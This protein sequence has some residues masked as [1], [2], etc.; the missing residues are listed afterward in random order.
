M[1]AAYST[2]HLNL[3]FSS[4]E[5]GDR[6]EV[7]RKS[8]WPLLDLARNMGLP[9]GIE[10]SGST[11]RAISQLD[12]TWVTA[13]RGLVEDGLVEIIASG[14]SQVI[15][16]ITPA[17]IN[18]LNVERGDH[19]YREILGISPKIFYV[20]EQTVSLGILR[21]LSDHGYRA[22]VLE[23]EN[24]RLAGLSRD[25]L[26]A[27]TRLTGPSPEVTVVWNS[28]RLFQ[29]LQ[30]FVAGEHD[31]LD[32][33]SVLQREILEGNLAS[34]IY[35]SDAEVFGFQV[36]RHAHESKTHDGHWE[37]VAE[38]LAISTDTGFHWKLPTT[39]LETV[40]KTVSDLTPFS[41]QHQI[42][43]KKQAKYNVGRWAVCGRN[44]YDLNSSCF[45]L[46]R[47]DLKISP[48][49][50]DHRE[51]ESLLRKWGSDYRTHI[52]EKR[53]LEVS[54]E[55]DRRKPA[56]NEWTPGKGKQARDSGIE[57]LMTGAHRAGRAY[58][59]LNKRRGL[60]L[61]EFGLQDERGERLK[62][63]GR[64]AF[65]D[66]DGIENQ[67]DFYSGSLTWETL[68]GARYADFDLGQKYEFFE[69]SP[70]AF[71]FW[72]E[73]KK[74][75][76][77][78]TIS[79]VPE[80]SEV[81]LRWEISWKERE[82]GRLRVGYLTFAKQPLESKLTFST[83]NGGSEIETF[84]AESRAFDMGQQVSSQVTSSSGFGATEG[85]VEVATSG[86][87]TTIEID[88]DSMGCLGLAQMRADTQSKLLRLCF[89]LQE[90][91]ETRH[92]FDTQATAFGCKI[93]VEPA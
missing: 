37:R 82:P 52:T 73:N 63:L 88:R 4:I 10:I 17:V 80:E 67:A 18:R 28:S 1:P 13:V 34:S 89:S 20:P 84:D 87:K 39:V 36:N 76:F 41:L 61:N 47:Q 90:V 12:S 24:F 49:K 70:Y 27:P 29:A 72:G 5:A 46:T 32:Y 93:K 16:P 6:P 9:Q 45:E 19:A 71:E 60:T 85:K 64:S 31:E 26:L 68:A 50:L 15:G 74:F 79:F 66:L 23:K 83:H 25:T 56:W 11:L 55:L 77:R 14:F 33:K 8:Y 22:L 48:H 38:A 86:T 59:S 42:I 51:Q 81:A 91:N 62:V 69:H 65:G 58:L 57:E 2:W 54:S 40:A 7:I 44:S 21:L 75:S 30:R 78:K 35:G 92:P 53:W 3:D 43:S